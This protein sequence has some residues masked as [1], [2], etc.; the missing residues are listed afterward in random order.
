MARYFMQQRTVTITNRLGL[1]ARAAARLVR[2]AA[3]FN[4]QIELARIDARQSP[5]DAK[6]IFGVLLL[7]AAQHTEIE[8]T[9]SG[10]DEA[11]AVAAL[12]QLIDDR[13]GEN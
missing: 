9:A 5:V 3:S 13:L 2:L 12:C 8:V 1:H 6:S 7:A 10:E 11:E 4:S